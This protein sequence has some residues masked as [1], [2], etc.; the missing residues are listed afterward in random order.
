M[1]TID[2]TWISFSGV[3]ESDERLPNDFKLNDCQNE[4][5]VK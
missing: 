5:E 2:Y 4:F 3:F 1:I